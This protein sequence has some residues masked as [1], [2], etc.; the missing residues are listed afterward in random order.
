MRFR[1]N[2]AQDLN[3]QKTTIAWTCIAII[4]E[5]KAQRYILQQLVKAGQNQR[6]IRLNLHKWRL[7][8]DGGIISNSGNPVLVWNFLGRS[9]HRST[10]KHRTELIRRGIKEFEIPLSSVPKMMLSVQTMAEFV[11]KRRHIKKGLKDLQEPRRS[12]EIPEFPH[13]KERGL[14]VLGDYTTAKKP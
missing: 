11:K 9:N 14:R 8:F 4:D 2:K 12:I 5:Y 3:F 6:R 7:Q 1:I 10:T 13:S